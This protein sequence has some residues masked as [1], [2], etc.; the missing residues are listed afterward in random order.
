MIGLCSV[1]ASQPYVLL[2]TL[3]AITCLFGLAIQVD[4]VQHPSQEDSETLLPWLLALLTSPE[5]SVVLSPLLLEDV[6]S[7]VTKRSASSS[8]QQQYFPELP[9]ALRQPFCG[10]V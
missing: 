7:L 3:M 9:S 5:A 6:K 10:P 1:D 2:S 4:Q 8:R